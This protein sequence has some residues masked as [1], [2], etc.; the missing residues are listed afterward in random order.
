MVHLHIHHS[1]RINNHSDF[2]SASLERWSHAI[3]NEQRGRKKAA[4]RILNC[5]NELHN[6]Q[7]NKQA[8]IALDLADL[9]LSDID[10]GADIYQQ[11]SELPNLFLQDNQL[12]SLPQDIELCRKLSLLCCNNNPL[13]SLPEE[14]ANCRNLQTLKCSHGNLTEIPTDI[15]ELPKLH[16][17]QVDNNKIC[18]IDETFLFGSCLSELN[19]NH[20]QLTRLPNFIKE[21]S[22][23]VVSAKHNPVDENLLLKK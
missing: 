3:P 21:F 6:T 5:I 22:N 14:M 20:N 2:N 17:L 18:F 12:T 15:F 11:L 7:P 9:E 1:H 8:F 4:A 23:G 16:T 19:L 10:W 13:Q